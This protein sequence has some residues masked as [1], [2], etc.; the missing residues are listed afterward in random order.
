[1]L[2]NLSVSLPVVSTQHGKKVVVYSPALD[3]S[4]AGK[5]LSE[6]RKRFEEMVPLF[7]EEIVEAGTV[8]DVLTE[9]GWVKEKK[10]KAWHPPQ[11]LNTESIGIRMPAFA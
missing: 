4:T 1:M 3:I 6:A 10:R 8:D 7:M 2:K 9:L 5:S 11:V